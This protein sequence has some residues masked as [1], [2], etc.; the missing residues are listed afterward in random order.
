MLR[1]KEIGLIRIN[2]K[3]NLNVTMMPY[4]HKARLNLKDKEHG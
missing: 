4:K 3:V 1:H 2:R